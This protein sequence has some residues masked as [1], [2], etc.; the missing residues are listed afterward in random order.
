MSPLLSL[1][2]LPSRKYENIALKY[3][4]KERRRNIMT[5]FMQILK[6]PAHCSKPLFS[7]ILSIQAAVLWEMGGTEEING[8]QAGAELCQAQG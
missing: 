8:K 2:S 6:I 5:V 1:L 7:I 4:R 3:E